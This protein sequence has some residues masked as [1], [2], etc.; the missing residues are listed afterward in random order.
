MHLLPV[1]DLLLEVTS[2]GLIQCFKLNG[3]SGEESS[4]EGTLVRFSCV[5]L[6]ALVHCRCQLLKDIKKQKNSLMCNLE[7]IECFP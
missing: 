7:I 4:T 5:M 6:H 2:A 1:W 3:F